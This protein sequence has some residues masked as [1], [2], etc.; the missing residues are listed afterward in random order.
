MKLKFP[1]RSQLWH[2]VNAEFVPSV[3]TGGIWAKDPD[4]TETP[5][6]T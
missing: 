5:K 4:D 6:N 2:Q 1:D 3:W